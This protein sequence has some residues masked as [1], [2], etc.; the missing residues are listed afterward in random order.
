MADNKDTYNRLIESAYECFAE[1]GFSATSVREI[2][3]RAGISQ[4]AMYTYFKSKEDL[5]I[6]IVKEE[7]RIAY[8]CYNAKRYKGSNIQRIYDITFAS[9]LSNVPLYPSSHNHLWLEIMA[10]SSRND[11]LREYFIQSDVILR[12]GIH[13]FLINGMKND[14]FRD[15]LDLNEVTMVIFSMID[16]LMARKAINPDFVLE[17]DIPGFKKLLKAMLS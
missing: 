5:V 7:Q 12:E 9:C 15:D 17:K 10:E 14:E 11:R 8:E 1:K 13:K 4:G 2:S 3:Q 6:A 16:G